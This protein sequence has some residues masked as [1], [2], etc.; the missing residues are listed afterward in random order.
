[1]NRI[2]VASIVMSVVGYDSTTRT[3][4]VTF[5]NGSVYEYLDVPPDHYDAL[6]AAASKGQFF[7]ARVRPAFRFNRV[8]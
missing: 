6:L 5:R 8:V 1:M 4:E 2:A 7:N 3:L